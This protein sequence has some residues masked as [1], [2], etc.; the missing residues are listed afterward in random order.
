MTY[1]ET[2]VVR[3]IDRIL[4]EHPDVDASVVGALD[5]LDQF[6]IGGAAA[7]DLVS[8][9]RRDRRPLLGAPVSGGGT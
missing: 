6:H 5:T 1:N 2:A 7:V 8:G 3:T 9:D 4:D